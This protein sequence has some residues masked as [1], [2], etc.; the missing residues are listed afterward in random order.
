LQSQYPQIYLSFREQPFITDVN[1][2]VQYYI[3]WSNI[4]LGLVKEFSFFCN[5]GIENL[6]ITFNK[7]WLL[8]VFT[9]CVLVQEQFSVVMMGLWAKQVGDGDS[10]YDCWQRPEH[11]TTS[12]EAYTVTPENPGSNLA[13]EIWLLHLQLLERSC[14]LQCASLPSL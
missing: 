1:Y 5:C 9:N 14:L 8:V 6:L 10:D 2:L 13:A 7:F 4:L 3:T 12:L 11:M